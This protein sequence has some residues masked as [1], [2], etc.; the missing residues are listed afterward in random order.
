MEQQAI[1]LDSSKGK[2]E[3]ALRG[4]SNLR[5][6]RERAMMIGQLA[7]QIG[8][9]LKRA[10]ALEL[11]EQARNLMGNSVRVENQE[12][13]NA[14]VELARAFSRYDSKRAFEIIEPLIDQFNEMTAAAFVL[15]NFGQLYYQNGELTLEN[16]NTVASI[17]TQLIQALGTLS[18][19]NFDRA[20]A[21]ADRSSA[22]SCASTLTLRS[23]NRRSWATRMNEVQLQAR[24][25][26]LTLVIRFSQTI[27]A[28]VC[29]R[30]PT[31]NSRASTP[32]AKLALHSFQKIINL[33]IS[34]SLVVNSPADAQSSNHLSNLKGLSG[35]VR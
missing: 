25:L 31:T 35:H 21:G 19:A 3:E 9:G 22:L 24:A 15:N 23:L 4:V 16:G 17:A 7:N 26:A 28:Y 32:A 20:K 13:M 14:M 6:S 30:S 2:I 18:R 5:T 29:D 33:K 27:V 8:P 12:Q 10:V 34:S 11:L 1:Y